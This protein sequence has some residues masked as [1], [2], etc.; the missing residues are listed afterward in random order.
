MLG[1]EID[2][3]RMPEA[4]ACLMGWLESP[5]ERC[6]YVVTPNTD[7]FLLLRE[8]SA[9]RAAYRDADLVLADGMP[10]VLAARLLKR[11]LPERVAGSDLV[12]ALFA[13][14]RPERPL[15]TYL[16][17]AAPGVGER[18]A[19]NI[20][21]RWPA[22]EIVGVESPPFGFE[23]DERQ[24]QAILRRLGESKPDVLILGLGTPKQELWMHTHRDQVT[25]RL[26][27]CAG[28]TIDFLAGEK[29][30]APMWMRRAG[31]E[32]LHRMV[33]EPRRLF[34][35]YF[36]NACVFPQLIWREWRMEKPIP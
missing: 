33:S 3:V 11:A 15:R 36:R 5:S 16:L 10:V 35:R 30:R 17:G 4:V 27:L 21:G 24:N 23:N 20:Q 1:I 28:A 19:R 29:R 32:W 6:R 9:M 2:A 12:P 14:A 26:A 7:H 8:N 18:A 34:P 22:V 31:L 25:A 13:T